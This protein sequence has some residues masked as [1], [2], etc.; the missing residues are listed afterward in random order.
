MR[1]DQFD[2][3]KT[4]IDERTR[5]LDVLV[6]KGREEVRAEKLAKLP[7]AEREVIQMLARD[8]TKRQAEMAEAIEN[9]LDVLPTDL[10]A[11]APQAEQ[12]KAKT[13]AAELDELDAKLGELRSA[14]ENVNCDYWQMRC[15]MERSDDARASRRLLHRAMTAFLVEGDLLTA[16]TDFEASFVAWRRVVDLHPE[17][18]TDQTAYLMLD[19]TRAYRAV[20]KQLDLPFPKEFALRSIIDALESQ[21]MP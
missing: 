6:P 14:R 3:T 13:L 10:A 5:Q 2:A 15:R 1:L 19:A 17:L 4:A 20:L 12:A 16:R 18:V 9:K 11:R 7:A 21:G 8:R